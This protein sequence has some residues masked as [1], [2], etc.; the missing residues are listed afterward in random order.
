MLKETTHAC[1]SQKLPKTPGE[2]KEGKIMIPNHQRL[3]K[4]SLVSK[5]IL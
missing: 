2:P 4:F 1:P 3:E 5:I